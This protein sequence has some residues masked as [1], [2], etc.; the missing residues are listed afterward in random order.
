MIIFLIQIFCFSSFNA[1]TN[2][3]ATFSLNQFIFIINEFQ[4][5]SVFILFK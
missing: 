5:N 1:S 4:L 3:L 2:S